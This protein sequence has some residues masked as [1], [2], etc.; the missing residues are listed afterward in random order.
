MDF[1]NPMFIIDG[2]AGLIIFVA[3]LLLTN[4][5]PRDIN[6]LYGYRT[7]RSMASQEAWD[8][9][10]IYSGKLMIR[11][12]AFL[13]AISIL[14]LFS[15]Q[16]EMVDVIYAVVIMILCLVIPIVRTEKALKQMFGARR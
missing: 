12:G 6:K 7:G 9:A 13:F 8:F 4:K 10:Q 15:Q 11:W 16:E 1:S 2:S 3:G 14:G 5:P